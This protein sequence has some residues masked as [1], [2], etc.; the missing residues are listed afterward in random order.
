[1]ARRILARLGLDFE[2]SRHLEVDA[3][4]LHAVYGELCDCLRNNGRFDA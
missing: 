4:K 2:A 3:A 1:L